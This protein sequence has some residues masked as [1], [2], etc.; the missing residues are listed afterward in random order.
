MRGE[1]CQTRV[2]FTD[3]HPWHGCRD[4]FVGA[5]NRIRGLGFQVPRIQMTW[6]AAQQDENAGFLGGAFAQ[7]LFCINPRRHHPRQSEGQS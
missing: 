7:T 1:F 4:R 2:K 3:L 5:A 6:P